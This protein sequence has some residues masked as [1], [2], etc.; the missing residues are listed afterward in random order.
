M[1]TGWA[2]VAPAHPFRHGKLVVLSAGSQTAHRFTN[3]AGNQTCEPRAVES[4]ASEA[5]IQAV[6]RGASQRAL[7]RDRPLV[8]P[9]LSDRRDAPSDGPDDR[10]HG[11]RPGDRPGDRAPGNAGRRVRAAALGRRAG[12]REPGRHRHAGDRRRRRHGDPRLGPRAPVLLGD[13]PP[14]A[15]RDRRRGC[16][17]DRRGRSAAARGPGRPRHA[18]RDHRG[19]APGRARPPARGADRALDVGR[20]VGPARRDGPRAPP[21][22]VLLDAP[23]RAPRRSTA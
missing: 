16:A 20:G 18:R 4:P 9:D 2:G 3:W 6:V 1:P 21:L 5:E 22:L 13:G 23:Q 11:H 10:R 19:R 14:H 15:P 12:A 8:Q 17:R 7:R